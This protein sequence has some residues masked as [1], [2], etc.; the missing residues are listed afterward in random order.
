MDALDE[1]NANNGAR[2][3]LIRELRDLGPHLHLLCTS[4]RLGDIEQVFETSSSLEI[5]AT[6]TDVR[7]FLEA[8][9][10]HDSSLAA[11]CARDKFLQT[12]I[13]E[14]LIE[15]AKGMYVLYKMLLTQAPHF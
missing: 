2:R 5:Q 9:I 11:F 15:K 14:K 6:D 1:C 13:I 3:E 12:T 8:H 4:R 10:S 7:T